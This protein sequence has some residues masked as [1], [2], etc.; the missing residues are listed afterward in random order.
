MFFLLNG[1]LL[2]FDCRGTFRIRTRAGKAFDVKVPP[3]TLESKT[4][5]RDISGST[6]DEPEK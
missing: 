5:S 2:S 3:F 6:D 1:E 4:A